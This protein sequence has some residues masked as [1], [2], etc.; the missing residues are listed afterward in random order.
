MYKETRIMHKNTFDKLC[1]EHKWL[2]KANRQQYSA[3]VDMLFDANGCPAHLNTEMIEEIATAIFSMSSELPYSIESIMSEFANN[4]NVYFD[5][6][7]A[8]W[9]SKHALPENILEK[10]L[11]DCEFSPEE[12]EY[13]SRGEIIDALLNY[14]G[15]IGYTDKILDWVCEIW[16][17]EL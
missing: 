7:V 13:L 6:C 4:C 3:V 8:P 11:F 12:L 10:L 16:N 9:N 17:I 5:K 2:N 14:E 15:I 1:D